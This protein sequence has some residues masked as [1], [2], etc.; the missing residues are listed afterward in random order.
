M[1]RERYHTTIQ[2]KRATKRIKWFNPKGII[3]ENGRQYVAAFV[4]GVL[5]ETGM[6]LRAVT[7]Q[8]GIDKR[9]RWVIPGVTDCP[10]PMYVAAYSA[11]LEVGKL[12]QGA[13]YLI[14]QINEQLERERAN[15]WQPPVGAQRGILSDQITAVEDQATEHL[16]INSLRKA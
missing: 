1:K 11:G 16:P 10:E 8:F 6:K 7:S 14:N 9:G 12:E 15:N 3:H 5:G 2:G 13:T 4:I